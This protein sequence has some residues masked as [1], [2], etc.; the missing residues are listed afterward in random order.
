MAERPVHQESD[1]F[2]LR[3]TGRDQLLAP[4]L[5]G[6]FFIGENAN[7]H[8]EMLTPLDGSVLECFDIRLHGFRHR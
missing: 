7:G 8:Q 4:P 1:V 5:T 2:S 6:P 3:W